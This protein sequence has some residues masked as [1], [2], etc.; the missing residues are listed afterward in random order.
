MSSNSQGNY[1]TT[2]QRAMAAFDKLPAV[3]RIALHE[4]VAN[5][6]PQPILTEYR[7]LKYDAHPVLAL[8]RHW[9]RTELEQRDR[10]R[11][12]A[13]GVYRGN[14]PDQ[15]APKRRARRAR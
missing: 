8:I 9:N 13:K 5:W 14:I 7:R 11:A 12:R 2:P 1:R 4:A 6:A 15:P 3:V 10:D